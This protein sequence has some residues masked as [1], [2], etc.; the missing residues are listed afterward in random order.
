MWPRNVDRVS[1]SM[2]HSHFTV[3]FRIP[4]MN[5]SHPRRQ[6]TILFIEDDPDD[7][8]LFDR[9][10]QRC[11]IPCAIHKAADVKEAQ[12]YLQGTSPYSDRARFPLPDLI[13][14]D[15][16]F[17]GSSG[18]EF[19]NWLRFQSGLPSLPVIC[20]TGSSDP[21]KLAQARDFGAVCISKDAL[22]SNAMPVI[23]KLLAS[24]VL[25]S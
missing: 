24:V 5:A 20:L 15:L 25:N 13:I 7:I 3:Q 12:A 17:R 18:L 16:A 19:L 6:C 4:M 14:T 2:S 8:F 11:G 9:A 22:F 1:W 21:A 23:Q 10:F